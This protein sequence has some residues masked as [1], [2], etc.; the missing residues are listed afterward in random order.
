[1]PAP[2]GREGGGCLG[3]RAHLRDGHPEPPVPHPLRE[4]GEPDPVGFD[5]EEDRTPVLRPDDGGRGDGDEGSAGTYQ[6]GRAV[7]DLAADDVEHDVGL[8]RVLQPVRLEVQEGLGAQPESGVPVGGTTGGDHPGTRLAGELDRDRTD[9]AGSAVDHDRLPRREPSVV[10]QPLPRGEPRDGQ[11]GGHGVVDVGGKR[12]QVACLHRGVLGQRTVARPVGQA[13]HPLADGEA[14]GAVPQFLDHARQ[15]VP[16]HTRCAVASGTVGPRT[17][18]G[19]FPAGETG[20]MHTHDD[21]VLG[22]VRIG[23]VRQGEPF[24]ARVTVMDGDGLHSGSSGSS[25]S[26][27]AHGAR[28]RSRGHAMRRALDRMLPPLRPGGPLRPRRTGPFTG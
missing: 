3:E 25:G 21:V 23:H 19:E 4:V 9:A 14:G 12:G 27:H 20:G 26:R 6:G 17:R 16:G 13:E 5:D 8:S 18:P 15:L 24:G 11:R 22:S 10:E 2:A 7:Q 1:M 28:S